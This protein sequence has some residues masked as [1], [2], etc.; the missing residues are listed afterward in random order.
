MFAIKIPAAAVV[1]VVTCTPVD[2]QISA[3]LLL[4]QGASPVLAMPPLT[5]QESSTLQCHEPKGALGSLCG[6]GGLVCKPFPPVL[7]REA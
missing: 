1:V 5:D 4:L 3:A 7:V 6:G 2:P